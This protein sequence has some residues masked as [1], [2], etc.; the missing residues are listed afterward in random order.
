MSQVFPFHRSG[1]LSRLKVGQGSTEGMYS[2]Q[3]LHFMLTAWVTYFQGYAL[4]KHEF[5]RTALEVCANGYEDRKRSGRTMPQEWSE[6][7]NSLQ[8]D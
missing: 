5:E 8:M 2:P 7:K 3:G 4:E 1:L 6:P